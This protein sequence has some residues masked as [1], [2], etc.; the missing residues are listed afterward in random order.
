MAPVCM[1]LV[2]KMANRVARQNADELQGSLALPISILHH[3]SQNVQISVSGFTLTNTEISNQICQTLTE[4]L[5]ESQRLATRVIDPERI[6][7]MFLDL[8]RLALLY[9]HFS[10]NYLTPNTEMM[11]MPCLR[12]L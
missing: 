5:G 6:E 11:N 7:P 3:Y 1:L 9:L 10:C 2:E 12:C 8:P 4:I